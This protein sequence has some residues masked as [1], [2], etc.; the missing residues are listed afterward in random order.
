[1]SR[2]R[3]LVA[4]RGKGRAER[5]RS[6]RVRGPGTSRPALRLPR[7]PL[8]CRLDLLPVAG[9]RLQGATAGWYPARTVDRASRPSPLPLL[10]RFD[11][12]RRC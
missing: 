12:L 3:R 5:P 1:M 10:N 2:A 7:S 6:D 11:D 8:A 9:R 4:G